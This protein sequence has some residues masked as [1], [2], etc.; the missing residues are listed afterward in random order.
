MYNAWQ[1]RHDAEHGV[2]PFDAERG[3][4]HGE[5][6]QLVQA[7]AE[8]RLPFRHVM[9]HPPHFDAVAYLDRRRAMGVRGGDAPFGVVGQTSDDGDAV[10]A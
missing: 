6:R 3:N 4:R 5:R 2:R 9:P 1:A 7:A 8:R 10:A